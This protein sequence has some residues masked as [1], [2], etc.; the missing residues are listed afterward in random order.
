MRACFASDAL[1]ALV[2]GSRF[3]VLGVC[4]NGRDK[5]VKFWD[6]RTSTPA[7]VVTLCERAYSMDTR[8]AMMVVATADR[9]VSLLVFV[10]FRCT[11][12]ASCEN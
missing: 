5:T 11:S 6:T 2:L 9:K 3:L 12:L 10:V 7:A 1:D 4:C 8:G